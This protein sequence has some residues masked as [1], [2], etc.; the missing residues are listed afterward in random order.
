MKTITI[1]ALLLILSLPANARN[2]EDLQCGNDAVE[3]EVG[4]ATVTL[5][6]TKQ[7]LALTIDIQ[8]TI[9]IEKSKPN[10]ALVLR[11]KRLPDGK[12]YL[13]GKLCKKV[14]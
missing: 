11:F 9:L 12:T 13:D 4:H 2:I 5:T 6:I 3:G 14:P 7:P 8:K 10:G 1:A